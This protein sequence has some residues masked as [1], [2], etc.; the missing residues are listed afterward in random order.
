M[1][2]KVINE[3][4]NS[5]KQV[6][7]G[8]LVK[9]TWQILNP[10]DVLLVRHDYNCGYI[11]QG[12]A[13][14]H[15][16]DSFGDLCAKKSLNVQS[17]AK[18]FSVLVG[19]KAHYLPK[20]YNQAYTVII[21]CGLAARLIKG[22]DMAAQWT[23]S[24]KVA[25]WCDMLDKAKPKIVVGIQPDKYLCRAGKI[26]KIPVY[27][28]QHGVIPDEDR[29]YG[30]KYRILT[31]IEDLPDGFLCWDEQAVATIAKWGDMKGI[32]A[33]NVG[34][35]WFLRFIKEDP[36][37]LLVHAAIAQGKACDNTRPC[38]LVSLQWGMKDSY[39]DIFLNEV[40]SDALERV[41]LDTEDMYNWILR[42]HPVQIRGKE[43][44]TA[45]RYLTD[46]FGEEKAQGWLK[47]SQVP[48]PIV[49]RQADIHIT[50]HSTV[51][52]EAAWMGVKSALLNQQICKE[53]KLESCYS[54]ERSI[55]MAEILP[56]DPEIIKQ[57]IAD[58]LAKGRAEPT[59][60][61]SSHALDAFIDEIASSCKNTGPRI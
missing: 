7:R 59:L 39:P 54:H 37:D 12:K 18:S 52:I 10:C 8:V 2:E 32:R 53:G 45:L 55:G 35:P 36:D 11:F 3:I 9:D 27:D 34:N 1:G 41:I 51:T 60:K 22:A 20:S 19:T 44:E 16:I 47:S 33:I 26:K 38:V 4:S 48:L 56:Q 49:L 6:L 43:R 15:L 50:Y 13:Y 58:T 28:L 46:T 29:W 21:L 42:L 23:D 31:P 14:A 61:E 17:I 57:W 40:L 30:S 24:R 25:L 5:I